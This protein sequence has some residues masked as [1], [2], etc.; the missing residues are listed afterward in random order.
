MP[1]I[2]SDPRFIVFFYLTDPAFGL[3]R[4]ESFFLNTAKKTIVRV[5]DDFLI[6]TGII[7]NV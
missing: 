3:S 1:R 7:L 5:H 4:T 2:C 6:V